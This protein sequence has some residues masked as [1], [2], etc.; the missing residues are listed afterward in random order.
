[1]ES[2]IYETLSPTKLFFR[3]AIPAVATSVFGA[4]YS[5]VDGIFVGRY[6]GEDALAAINLIMPIIMIAEA[7]SNMIATGASVNMSIL[8]GEHKREDASAV[9][10]LSIKFILILSFI[11]GVLGFV[12]ASRFIALIAP[13]AGGDASA[14]AE[15]YL[16]IYAVFAPL[17]MV[18]FATDNYL[19]VCGKQKLSMVIN[20]SSQVI[21]VVLDFVLIVVLHKGVKA[22]AAASCIAIALGSVV[23]LLMFAGRKTDVYYT[24][25]NI[26]PMQFF[27][28]VANGSSEFFSNIAF[29]IM[30][31][32][33]NLFLLKYGG[34]TAVA[35]FSI[36]MYV[37]SII[38]MVNFGICD[39]LQPAISYC[40]GAKRLDRV[41]AIFRRIIIAD[42]ITS[43]AAF[44]FMF[45]AGGSVAQIFIKPDDAKLLAVSMTAVKL[46]SFSYLA[47][48]IDMSFSSYFTALD[49][50][51]RSLFV[52]VFGALI[53]PIAFLFIL[54]PI[55]GLNG[56][57]LM[58]S[59]AA[60]FSGIM[61]LVLY[62]TLN[63]DYH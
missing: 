2:V 63:G 60:A 55:W 50:P 1:M 62:K 3:C 14:A 32:I 49:R 12:F 23:S 53:F 37:D 48:W 27:R 17:V 46:F 43:S 19:R 8:L 30:S 20:I 18:Y 24:K 15:D 35:A 6:L 31:V 28:I 54:T 5:V 40:Y 33:M 41:K 56:V 4:L 16:K 26:A 22:A 7:F 59:V 38:G 9:F 52:S 45:L 29:S 34:A 11:I 36:V 57:W 25:E 61:T 42:I 58:P 47:G 10:S 13:G 44:L 51:V 39:S 21:N